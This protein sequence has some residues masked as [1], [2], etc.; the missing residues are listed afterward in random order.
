MTLGSVEARANLRYFIT[1]LNR[2]YIETWEWM[3]LLIL[4]LVAGIMLMA[5][6]GTRWMIVFSSVMAICAVVQRFVLTPE[7]TR[8]G[9]AIDFLP[10]T[11]LTDDHRQYYTYVNWYRVVQFSMLGLSVVV[12]LRLLMTDTIR[13][14]LMR[15]STDPE[16]NWDAM[17][18][19][20]RRSR[21]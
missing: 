11:I 15:G 20:T 10:P 17:D 1:E 16:E 2:S 3:Q 6:G 8:L 12:I 14:L 21:S 4:L 9:R 7:I 13:R 18:G 5:R 19:A